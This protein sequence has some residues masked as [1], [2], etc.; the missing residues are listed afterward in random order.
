MV[1]RAFNQENLRGQQ[2][3]VFPFSELEIN[4]AFLDFRFS[5]ELYRGV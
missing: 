5:L 2:F 3:P 4:T 1:G